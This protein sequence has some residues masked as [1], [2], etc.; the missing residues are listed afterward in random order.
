VAKI[1]L[2][3]CLKKRDYLN[4]RV[5][6][7]EECVKY[8]ELYQ[9]E[10]FFS[11]AIDFFAKAEAKEKLKALLPQIIEE[12]DVFLFTKI[13]RLLKEDPPQTAWQEIGEIAFKLGKW[14]FALRAFQ[15]LGDKDKVAEIE[16]LLK[17]KN[18]FI[19]TAALPGTGE[20]SR[21]Q[22]RKKEKRK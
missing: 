10:G 3:S 8:G 11:D 9:R 13:Y 15:V 5:F 16:T 2:L 7:R 17:E 18:M 1:T 20:E 4:A 19:T 12:G 22:K 14:Q 21:S 6:D